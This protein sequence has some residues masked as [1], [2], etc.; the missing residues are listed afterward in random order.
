MDVQLIALVMA[1]GAGLVGF[2]AGRVYER[3]LW[4]RLIADG[5]LPRPGG[6]RWS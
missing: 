5:R 3:V 4:N 1:L 2:L 6:R